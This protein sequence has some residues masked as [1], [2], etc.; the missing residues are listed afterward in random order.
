[1]AQ[2]EHLS[3]RHLVA[4]LR[5]NGGVVIDEAEGLRLKDPFFRFGITTG[6]FAICHF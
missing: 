1:M 2:V 3:P 5:V 6:T 4:H